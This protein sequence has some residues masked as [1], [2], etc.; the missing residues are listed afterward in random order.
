MSVCTIKSTINALKCKE[1]WNQLN[2][3]NWL[4]FVVLPH[5]QLTLAL[6]RRYAHASHCVV[7]FTTM[8]QCAPSSTISVSI[9]NVSVWLCVNHAVVRFYRVKWASHT[10]VGQ[11]IWQLRINDIWFACDNRRVYISHPFFQ[12][13]HHGGGAGNS[14]GK[15]CHRLK[16]EK[17]QHIG[18]RCAVLNLA[19][20]TQTD[21]PSHF[22]C[23][24]EL[25]DYMRFAVYC[26]AQPMRNFQIKKGH[27]Q[28]IGTVHC[29][30]NW[31]SP[32]ILLTWAGQRFPIWIWEY[33]YEWAWTTC[34][35]EW[36]TY[37]PINRHFNQQQSEK[38]ETEKWKWVCHSVEF[39]SICS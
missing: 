16:W 22:M 23:Q 13:I 14:S 5:T 39:K 28:N 38:T 7:Q 8:R 24:Y 29:T 34:H 15:K 31:H 26:S 27:K 6:I 1:N 37:L 12:H 30:H 4:H 32:T 19:W 17:S 36:W 11:S 35:F 18:K 20:R 9:F 2:G 21:Y 33:E 25:S 3:I 10:R